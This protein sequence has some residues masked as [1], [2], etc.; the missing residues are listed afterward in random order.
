MSLP[1]VSASTYKSPVFIGLVAVMS[2][3]VVLLLHHCVL[4]TFC[5]RRR[6]RRRHHRGPSAQQ[7][8]QQPEEDEEEEEA[9]SV[10][11]MSSSSRAKLVQVVVCPYR[12]AE[13]WS[14]A[15]CPVCLSDFS[16]GEAVRVL[17]ECMHYFHVD[18][19][20]TWLRSNTSC[21]LCRAETT[22]TPTPT[23]SPGELHHL[24]L[25]VSLEE[26]LVRT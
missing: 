17:P 8:V 3:A 25:S 21:P 9:S 2:V 26:I 4:V 24:S 1:G 6:R 18:C 20:E 14:E 22:P 12:K 23:P 13:E 16:D 5:D 11:M 10:D 15:M 7:H 19:I